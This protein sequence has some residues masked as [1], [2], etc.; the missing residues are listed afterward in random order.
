MRGGYSYANYVCGTFFIA[1]NDLYTI[2][3]Q[4]RGASI[5]FK[6]YIKLRV[7]HMLF[8]VVALTLVSSVVLSV[9]MSHFLLLIPA[10]TLAQPYH[11]K[12]I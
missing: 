3:G 11:L 12:Y 1:M 10:G 6:P 4:T 9:L 5:S 7:L 2:A 8:V